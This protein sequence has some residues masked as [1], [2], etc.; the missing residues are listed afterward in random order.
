[1]KRIALVSYHCPPVLNAE[2]I[3]VWKTIRALVKHHQVT[4]FAP[5]IRQQRVDALLAVPEGVTVVRSADPQLPGSFLSR[6][7]SRL[8]GMVADENA[9]WAAQAGKGLR[10]GTYDV[11]YSRSQPGASHIAALRMKAALNIPWVAQFSDP[12]ATNPYHSAHTKLRVNRDLDFERAVVNRA[13]RLIFPTEEIQQMYESQYPT[14]KVA[15]KS[16]ILPHHTSADLYEKQNG[17]LQVQL[18]KLNLAYVGDF[19]GSRS[20]EPIL[21]ACL[22]LLKEYPDLPN[23]LHFH[24]IGNV[25]SKFVPLIDQCSIGI[26]TGRMGYFESLNAMTKADGLLLI[27]APNP[28]GRTPFL[29]SKLIDYLGATKPIFGITETE[30]TAPD[31]IRSFGYPVVRPTD[32]SGIVEELRKWLQQSP[33]VSPKSWDAFST[34]LVVGQLARIFEEFD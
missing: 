20:P 28:T 5:Q 17:P 30:G 31:L 33:T 23:R 22:Q 15:G 34:D 27:D 3:L 7:G 26:S 18:G 1:M 10:T 19:Y 9:L 8:L 24:F 12:W 11:L 32:A 29:P 6:A 13:D 2:S 16:V 4:V 21:Q 25:E 14:L